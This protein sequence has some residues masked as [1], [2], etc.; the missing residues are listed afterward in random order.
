MS[1]NLRYYLGVRLL[2]NCAG[3]SRPRDGPDDVCCVD[4][5]GMTAGAAAAT[6]CLNHPD[7]YP[8]Q[9][10]CAD[11]DGIGRGCWCSGRV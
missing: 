7:D 8:V 6:G 10:L 2:R 5:T 4:G 3:Y 1:L 11:R 9:L